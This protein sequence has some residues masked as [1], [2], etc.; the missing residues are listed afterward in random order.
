MARP[1]EQAHEKSEARV[2]MVTGGAQGLGRAIADRLAMSGCSLLIADLVDEQTHRTTDELNAA[3]HPAFPMVLDVTDEAA[4]VRAFAE[5]EARFGWLDILI[6]NAGVPGKR[7]PVEELSLSA[8]EMTIRTNLSSTFLMSRAAIPLMRRHRWGRIVNISSQVARGR[9][10]ANRSDYTASKVGVVGFS[11]VLADEVGRDGITV[12]CV[13]PSRIKT[14]MTLATS[15]G[16]EQYFQE[17]AA[18]TAVGRLGEPADIA[19]AVA[20]LCSEEAAF[21]TGAVIDVNGG[22]MML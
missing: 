14:A 19:H 8:W 5:I 2:A 22:T 20:W 7:V 1:P 15:A 21:I 3:G 10:G 13:A 4:V 6:N 9:P 18:A 12:N 11:R 16:N 17:G